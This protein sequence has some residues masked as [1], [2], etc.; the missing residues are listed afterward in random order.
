MPQQV[1]NDVI[2]A[3][4]V[5]ATN[6]ATDAIVAAKI[7]ANAVTTAKI[8]D[9]NV[10][11][12]KLSQPFTLATVQATT[13]GTEKDFAIPAWAKRIRVLLNGVS[14]NTA[15]PRV[16]LG[17]SGG[18]VNTG[19]N[20]SGSVISSAVATATLSAGFDI[21]LNAGAA[22]ADLYHGAF[23]I[24]LIDAATN[25][26]S[27]YGVFSTSNVARTHTTAGTIALAGALTTV[28]LTSTNGT[29]TF[30]AGSVNVLYD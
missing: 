14:L 3:N 22:T 2:A 19:Y 28:R 1:T 5:T 24:G 13:S 20:G 9:A 25:T 10:T 21:Y 6:V 29:D 30:D 26:W 17:T 12:A 8:L 16:R 11:P 27:V 15:Q 18:I 4:A 7:Q 23:E